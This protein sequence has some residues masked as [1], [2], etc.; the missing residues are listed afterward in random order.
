MTRALFSESAFYDI[1]TEDVDFVEALGQIRTADFIGWD[2]AFFD[3]IGPDAVVER[4]LAFPGVHHVHE[5]PVYVPESEELLFADTSV[6]GSL[7]AINVNTY[8]VC[9]FT[10][11]GP[12]L[13]LIE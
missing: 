3:I 11:D 4:I 5:A 12:P 10:T 1:Q 13:C 8:Q 9:D 6:V 7:W 2:E